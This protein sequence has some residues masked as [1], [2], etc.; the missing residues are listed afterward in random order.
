MDT[1]S[2]VIIV[3]VCVAVVGATIAIILAKKKG[4]PISS[5][6]GDCSKCAC[7]CNKQKEDEE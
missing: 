3:C 2:I 6:C 5:C 7:G 1:I 4:K